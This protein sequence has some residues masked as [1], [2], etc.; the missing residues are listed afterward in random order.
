[1]TD[2]YFVAYTG[3]EVKHFRD[4]LLQ[5]M[6]NV[7]KSVFEKA[8]HQKQYDRRVNKRLIQTQKSKI[9][10]GKAVNDDLVVT[11][12][13]GTESEV[14]D[15]NSRSGNDTDTDNANIRP[16]YDEEPM[17]KV[18]LNAECNIFAIGQQHTEQL[19][20]INEGRVDHISIR[21][22]KEEVY[23]NQ[24]DG[25]V[26]PYH[27]DK[28]YHLKK[29]PY[30]L[31]QASR[32]CVGIPMAT[33]HL[34]ADL[35]GTPVDQTKYRSM[36]GA[37]MYLTASRPD[38]M[39][40]TCYCARY[41]AKPTENHLTAV[42]RTFRYLKDTIHI[43]LWYPKDTGFELTAFSD[44]NHARCLDTR[45]ST[46]GGIRFLSGDKLVSWSSKKQDCTL[47]SS[48][49]VEYVSLSVCCAQVLW[50][51]TQLTDYGFHFDKIPMY[52]DSKEKVEKGIV[53]LFF[54]GTEYQSDLFT[55]A[56]PKERF[57]YLVRRLGMRCL[58]P[59]EL[60]ALAN[61]SA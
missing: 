12:S 34:D 56:L 41:Q 57:K 60:E 22:L 5:H 28:V 3:I 2:K 6:G 55:K 14:Q 8:R 45:K 18:Q 61:K 4:T 1:M 19:E 49:E 30:G 21:F 42:K 59:K 25:F 47:M 32:A 48:A 44:S 26:D 9:D 7:K 10:M 50:M 23:V 31:K 43:G 33:K 24:P 15:D 11:K 36:V 38:I 35:S 52:C 16:I 20:I 27:P 40:A 58:T 37:L 13:S 54:I 39:H 29:A 51:R 46:S 17:T 53:E